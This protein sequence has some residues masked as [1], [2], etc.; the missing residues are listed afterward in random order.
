M[1]LRSPWRQVAVYRDQD[2]NPKE[3]FI[4][5]AAG[6]AGMGGSSYIDSVILR[7]RDNTACGT[8]CDPWLQSSD[9]TLEQRR[10]YVQNWR[11]D[12][13]ALL[14]STGEPVEWIRYTAYGTPTVHPIAD[15]NGDGSVTSADYTAWTNLY[16]NGI[17]TT[18]VF[19]NPDLNRDDAYPDQADDDYFVEQYAEAVAKASGFDQL[20]TIGN[21]K[22]YAGY[23]RDESLTMWHV[24]HRVLDS[25]S[26][27]WTRKDPLGY[28]DGVSDVEY[29]RSKVLI[30]VDAL[31]LAAG[32]GS[33]TPP[34]VC[35]RP[36][37]GGD[38]FT[39]ILNV[40]AKHC[41]VKWSCAAGEQWFPIWV[42]PSTTRKLPTGVPC[43][44]ATPQ[45]ID[46]CLRTTPHLDRPRTDCEYGLGNNCHDGTQKQVS[47]CCLLTTW[48]PSWYAEGPRGRCVATAINPFT[49]MIEC[50]TWEFEDA[51][52]KSNPFGVMECAEWTYI[53]DPDRPGRR[54]RV[55]V[56]WT[57]PRTDPRLPA[58]DPWRPRGPLVPLVERSTIQRSSLSAR[59]MSYNTE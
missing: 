13:T 27:K 38:W 11:A 19:L 9:G 52:G 23:E 58:N 20:S 46:D 21:R 15:I 50:I 29:G 44:Q 28:I 16:N 53:P 47:T 54:D 10:Y 37:E 41:E 39:P 26:G 32:T 14:K 56:R 51:F 42:D 33:L 36:M 3:A 7:D 12:V 31:G 43:G 2:A 55:C 34:G 57:Y 30:T 24:R 48:E 6:L 59:H 35:C 45:Q 40:F 4:Y 5:H 22:G 25:K 1:R 8:G 18:A 17:S 49:G